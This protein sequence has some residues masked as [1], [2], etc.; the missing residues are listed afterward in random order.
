MVR[1]NKERFK[2]GICRPLTLRQFM[3]VNQLHLYVV[4]GNGNCMFTAT[5][6]ASGIFDVKKV[7]GLVEYERYGLEGWI[8]PKN[9]EV[10]DRGQEF[11][12][13]YADSVKEHM[14]VICKATL[15]TE[16]D[17]DNH[18]VDIRSALKLSHKSKLYMKTYGDPFCLGALAIRLERP[19]VL[20]FGKDIK[21]L[22]KANVFS[23]RL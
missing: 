19:I 4:P 13:A 9:K 21:C 23:P 2:F 16:E 10:W 20:I 17:L 14:A 11:G 8:L 12:R 3:D 15:Q 1:R 18:I 5:A 7:K 6:V 22:V